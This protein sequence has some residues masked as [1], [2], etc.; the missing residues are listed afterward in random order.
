MQTYFHTVIKDSRLKAGLSKVAAARL[1]N[2]SERTL[3]SYENGSVGVDDEM[4]VR[5]AQGYKCP[6]IIYYWT[7]DNACG[8][9]WLPKIDDNC[10][11]SQNILSS[12][13]SVN[14]MQK[15]YIPQLVVIGQDNKIDGMEQGLFVK[16]REKGLKPLMKSTISLL[17]TA[18][19][20]ADLLKNR[21]TF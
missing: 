10:C 8:R 4:A 13:A 14:A 7:Q 19:K 5:M 16:I 11:L 9:M 20:K 2:V 15:D 17:F 3:A 6:A 21:P 12:F 18:I 1:L